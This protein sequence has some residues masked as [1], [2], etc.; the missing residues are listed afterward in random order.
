MGIS[1][2]GGSVVC[3]A[4]PLSPA[5]WYPPAEVRRSDILQPVE[6]FSALGLNAHL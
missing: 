3:V 6:S 5:G 2:G 1:R 4:L